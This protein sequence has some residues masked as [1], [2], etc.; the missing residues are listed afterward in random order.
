MTDFDTCSCVLHPDKCRDVAENPG[1]HDTYPDANDERGRG[2]RSWST[3]AA[4]ADHRRDDEGG[5]MR[6]RASGISRN[7]ASMSVSLVVEPRV[8]RTAVRARSSSMP[9]AFNT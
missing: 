9:S 4:L 3:G 2:D 5:E 7:T 8:K 6:A 1:N